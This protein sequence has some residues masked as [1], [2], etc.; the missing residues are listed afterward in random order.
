MDKSIFRT[1]LFSGKKALITGGGTGIGLRTAKE[2]IA[3]GGHAVLAGRREEL[4]LNAV[5]ELGNA[6]YV[7]LNIREEE[8]VKNCFSQIVDQGGVDFLVNNA[9]GQ[10]PCPADQMSIK[11]W[12]AVIDTNLT[13]TFMMCQEA[14]NTCFKENGGK[15][16]NVIANIWNGFPLLSHTGAARAGVDNL[17]KSLAV[18]WGPYGVS[19]NSV[20]PGVIDSSGLDTYDEHY[21]KVVRGMAKNNQSGRLGTEGEVAASILF[22]LSPVAQYITG[23]TLRV[24]GG[25]PLYHPF[26]PPK[27]HD[28]LPAELI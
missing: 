23:T 17:T 11:G 13:G 3:L 28:K 21:Q 18:E 10:F 1:E 20:A 26:H 25:E 4:L 5:K 6:S 15:I 12:K 16:V 22:L 2:F 27:Q 8:S 14:F 7:V 19:I 24:D 9:G